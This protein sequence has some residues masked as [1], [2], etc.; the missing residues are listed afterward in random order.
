MKSD[1]L[2]YAN[3]FFRLNENLAIYI[4]KNL[5]PELC[6]TEESLELENQK[7]VINVPNKGCS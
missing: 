1:I 7:S 6:E 3:F 2:P 4:T 5:I